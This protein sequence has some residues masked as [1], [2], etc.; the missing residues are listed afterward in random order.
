MIMND[1]VGSHEL[2]E[3]VMIGDCQVELAAKRGGT[4]LLKFIKA[5]KHSHGLAQASLNVASL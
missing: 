3:R 2:A 5:V 4:H 1:R